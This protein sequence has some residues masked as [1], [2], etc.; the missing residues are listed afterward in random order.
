MRSRCCKSVTAIDPAK[1]DPAVAAL[2]NVRHI[3]LRAQD[4][5]TQGLLAPQSC[6]LLVSDCNLDFRDLSRI[7][8]SMA[9]LLKPNA[10]VILTVKLYRRTSEFQLQK[11]IREGMLSLAPAGFGGFRV[12]HL[13]QNSLNERTVIGRYTADKEG[14]PRQDGITAAAGVGATGVGAG[15]G[16]GASAG[17]GAGAGA[18]V[19]GA[20]SLEEAPSEASADTAEPSIPAL[21]DITRG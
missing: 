5:I 2:P 3:P 1:L 17:A 20:V 19:A 15:A 8:A 18:G 4:A 14:A 6:D 9:S 10:L 12:V 21:S 11:H 13:F 7:V 16:A